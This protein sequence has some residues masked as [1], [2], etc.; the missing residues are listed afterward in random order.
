I[1]AEA[2]FRGAD[3]VILISTARNMPELYGVE[4]HFVDNTL[5]MKEEILNYFDK[6]D[7]IVMTAAV[8]D[9]I[10]QKTYDF[11]LK[12]DQDLLSKLSFKENENILKLLSEIKKGNQVLAG[13]AAESGE[14][15]ISASKKI[16]GNKIDMIVVNDI[17]RNDIG[18]ESDFN[19][20]SIISRNGD[21]RKIQKAKKRIIAREIMN[22][23][24]LK[25]N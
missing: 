24:I 4:T 14:D 1:A 5:Q 6:S 25:L 18:F 9:I 7:I 3:K 11:K 22:E 2:R 8:S 16:I 13:F 21:V 19:E 12:K 17:S 15:I 20:V 10:P 23:I